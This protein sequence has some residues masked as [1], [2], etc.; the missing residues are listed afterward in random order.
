MCACECVGQRDRKRE[1]H[2]LGRHTHCCTSAASMGLAVAI[3]VYKRG[4][5]REG[6]PVAARRVGQAQRLH[7]AHFGVLTADIMHHNAIGVES[8]RTA[9]E[10][11]RDRERVSKWAVSAFDAPHAQPVQAQSTL[12]P[13]PKPSHTHTERE[14]HTHRET[15]RERHTHTHSHTDIDMCRG[16]RASLRVST[17]CTQAHAQSYTRIHIHIH[18]SETLRGASSRV[19]GPHALVANGAHAV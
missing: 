17:S 16:S 19:P 11:D 8:K 1:V 13:R 7:G 6:R 12:A 15:Q 4:R 18:T 2:R 14:R 9:R 5:E 3:V 10:R